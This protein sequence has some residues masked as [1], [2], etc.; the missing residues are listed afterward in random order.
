M[1]N[2]MCRFIVIF[3]TFFSI[4][5]MDFS[6]ITTRCIHPLKFIPVCLKFPIAQFLICLCYFSLY[7]ILLFLFFL[8]GLLLFNGGIFCPNFSTYQ[9]PP[10]ACNN[11]VHFSFGLG[12][13]G[14]LTAI[15]LLIL[16]TLNLLV[17]DK[18]HHCFHHHSYI[19]DAFL[20]MH[21]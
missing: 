10:I 20:H 4:Q 8:L 18:A 12:W 3:K 21:Q 6:F 9:R 7:F 15:F 1:T 13:L 16:L 2:P 19:I 17:V 11:D 5:K 14:C